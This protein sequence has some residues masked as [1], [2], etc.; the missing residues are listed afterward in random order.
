[1]I[2]QCRTLTNKRAK[3]RS[4]GLICY[5]KDVIS[6][7]IQQIDGTIKH[8]DRLWLKLNSSFFGFSSDLFLCFTYISPATSTSTHARGNIWQLLSTEVARFSMHGNILLT[9]DLNAR[10]SVL[11]D[12]NE[13]D[14]NVFVPLP[15]E[16]RPD[17]RW[18]RCNT[19]HTINTYGKELLNLCVSS[20]LRIVNGRI[21]RDKDV[22]AFTCY[23][24]RGS[25]VVDYFVASNHFFESI[26]DLSI[27]DL[28]VYSDHCPIIL[29]IVT[30]REVQP[31][32]I[33]ERNRAER[34]ISHRG[35]FTQN[36]YEVEHFL[37]TGDKRLL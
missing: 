19:D 35:Y 14:L 21:G 37:G 36:Y 3:R 24:P 8:E 27:G 23:T 22:G 5:I 29:D 33:Y 28:T 10:T 26:F 6:D 30:R 1:M 4:G 20:N 13:H 31:T 17:Y 2:T 15:T 34:K 11:P 7:G 9:G 25:S 12:Y 32:V 18:P 16:Y